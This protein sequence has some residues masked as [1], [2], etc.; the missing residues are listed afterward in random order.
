MSSPLQID[1]IVFND[2]H[3]V[4]HSSS[5]REREISK[6]RVLGEDLVL[7]RTGGKA[8]VWKDLCVHRG[9]K[10]SLGWFNEGML[11]CSYHGW[12]YNSEGQCVRFPAHPVQKPPPTA[13]VKTYS[14]HEKYG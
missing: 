9:S 6:A 3:V 5:L 11:T 1:P 7:W 8:K 2:W 14:S 12:T 10:L 13:H 4:A